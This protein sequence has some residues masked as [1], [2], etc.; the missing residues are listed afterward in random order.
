MAIK[1]RAVTIKGSDAKV[2]CVSIYPQPNGGAVF[3][4]V[5]VTNDSDGRAVALKEA[6]I[7]YSGGE[8]NST[9]N[10]LRFCLDALRKVNELEDGPVQL[11]PKAE[12][13]AEPAA[14]AAPAAPDAPN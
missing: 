8:N 4:V 6:R 12:A 2:T 1:D 9:D 3:S 10:L 7:E 5:G 14:P 11:E 13:A